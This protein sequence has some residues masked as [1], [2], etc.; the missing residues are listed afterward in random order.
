MNYTYDLQ[1]IPCEAE[2]GIDTL[3]SNFSNFD[4]PKTKMLWLG[5]HSG[6]G[7]EVLW[8]QKKKQA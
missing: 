4:G 3:C 6:C 1:G 2:V 8:V 7:L 5:P